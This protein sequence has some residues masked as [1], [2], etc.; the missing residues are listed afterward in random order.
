MLALLQ[1][2][3]RLVQWSSQTQGV[4]RVLVSLR[5]HLQCV[6]NAVRALRARR[7]VRLRRAAH[8]ADGRGRRLQ[9]EHQPQQGLLHARLHV[10]GRLAE[11]LDQVRPQH[12][13]RA[14]QQPYLGQAGRLVQPRDVDPELEPRLGMIPRCHQLRETGDELVHGLVGRQSRGG[15]HVKLVVMGRVSVLRALH[16]FITAYLSSN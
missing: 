9:P 14:G 12:A 2:G 1:P 3:Q 10:D 7:V 16:V 4:H 8:H 5:L 15:A 6:G 11:G 13:Q